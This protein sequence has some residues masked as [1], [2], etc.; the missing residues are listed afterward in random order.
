M[1][2]QEMREEMRNEQG[3]PAVAARRRGLQSQP[4]PQPLDV[5][6]PKAQLV[7]VGEQHAVAL[8]YDPQSMTSPAVVARG[9]GLWR[10]GCERWPT[11]PEFPWPMKPIWPSRFIAIPRSAARCPRRCGAKSPASWRAHEP[12]LVRDPWRVA[13]R[14]AAIVTKGTKSAEKYP[15]LAHFH[16]VRVSSTRVSRWLAACNSRIAACKGPSGGR[17][18][19]A[20]RRE[21]GSC[22]CDSPCGL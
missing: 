10:I 20:A 7:V 22:R 15:D 12:S 9:A 5:A 2:P 16:I 21:S 14:D 11:R 17:S 18:R 1:T 19:F 6:V 13:E 3:D 8:Q 4:L